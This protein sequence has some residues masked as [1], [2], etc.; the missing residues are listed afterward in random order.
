ML[1]NKLNTMKKGKYIVVTGAKGIGKSCVVNTVTNNT[2]GVVSL[3]VKQGTRADPIIESAF[4]RLTEPRSLRWNL[5]KE[6]KRVLFFYNLFA[7]SPPIVVL[8]VSERMEKGEFAEIPSAARDLADLGLRVLVDGSTNSVPLEALRTKRQI[9]LDLGPMP[10]ETMEEIVDFKEVIDRLKKEDLF[11]VAWAVIGGVP[12][13]FENLCEEL[14]YMKCKDEDAGI[15]GKLKNLLRRSE[16]LEQKDVRFVVERFLQEMI[17]T[18]MAAVS[19]TR[20]SFPQMKPILQKFQEVDEIFLD[21]LEKEET[22]RPSPDKV[23]RE[24]MRG[25]K[26]VLVPI[27]SAMALVLKHDLR[28]EAPSIQGLK[29]LI[30]KKSYE[31]VEKEA[32]HVEKEGNFKSYTQMMD[33]SLQIKHPNLE[34]SDP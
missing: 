27:D 8:Q 26:V 14:E 28:G 6:T 5:R 19:R 24:K 13:D 18:S 12:A 25:N 22:Q 4:M 7:R 32:E 10:K 34:R 21:D 11:E 2:C 33:F 1:K 15:F 16:I 30:S 20:S 3:Q 17:A 23:L 9:V 31:V 29:K